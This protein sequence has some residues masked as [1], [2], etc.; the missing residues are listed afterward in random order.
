MAN[1][2]TEKKGILETYIKWSKLFSIALIGF[3]ALFG[4]SGAVAAGALGVV[5]DKITE[6]ILIKNKNKNKK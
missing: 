1:S 5:T 6:D 3:G 4:S 2:E